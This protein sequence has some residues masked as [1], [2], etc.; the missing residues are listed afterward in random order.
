MSEHRNPRSA[1]SS[2]WFENGKLKRVVVG[3]DVLV[4]IILVLCLL[5]GLSPDGIWQMLQVFFK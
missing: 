5:M 1:F 3:P 2:E 4:F